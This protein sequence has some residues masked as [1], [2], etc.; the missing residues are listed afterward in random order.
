L[1]RRELLS[2]PV[3]I[4]GDRHFDAYVGRVLKRSQ[5]LRFNSARWTNSTIAFGPTTVTAAPSSESRSPPTALEIRV[6]RNQERPANQ[7]EIEAAD[8]RRSNA[9]FSENGAQSQSTNT[10]T[11][12]TCNMSFFL[13]NEPKLLA[14]TQKTSFITPSKGAVKSVRIPW[15]SRRVSSG[16]HFV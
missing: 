11:E 8:D 5:N 14:G 10:S 4:G 2:V 15:R 13:R 16:R 12:K 7:P 9:T 6:N 3:R 1:R